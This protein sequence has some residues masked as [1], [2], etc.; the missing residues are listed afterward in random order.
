[1]LRWGASM[2]NVEEHVPLAPLTTFELGG[3][4]RWLATAT[5]EADVVSALSWAERRGVPLHVLGGGSNLVVG[6]AGFDGLVLR[7]AL[8]GVGMSGGG[9]VLAAAGEPWDAVVR[10]SVELGHAGL[11]CLAGIPGLVGA[12]PIQNVGAYG[13]EVAETIRRVR[14]VD[15]ASREILDLGPEECDFSYRDSAFKRAPERFIVVEVAFQLSP[16]G[17]PTIR[18]AELERALA[19]DPSPALARVRDTIMALRRAKS[20]VVD[21]LDENRRSAGFFFTN[22]IVSP[23][24]AARVVAVALGLGLV[25]AADDVPQF[26][27]GDGQVKLAAG[28]LIER[29][30]MAKGHRE[31]PVGISSRHALALVHHGGGTTEALLDL[32]RR[33]RGAVEDRFGVTL[34][35]EPVLLGC[36]L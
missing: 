18:Y 36:A 32:A 5:R 20:M 10:E 23:H 12:T 21:P 13:Q 1:M 30:G 33:V 6:D 24:D 31:G 16:G 9:E 15:R 8:R 35:P 25:S 3:A 7:L 28:W 34:I 11:E 4:A 26:A 19:G 22:P 17:A 29:A 27:V 14:V 2:L